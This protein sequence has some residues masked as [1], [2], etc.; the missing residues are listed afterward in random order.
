M[1]DG[2]IILV[3]DNE[4][5]LK[6]LRFVLSREFRTVVG[7]SNPSLLPA[8]LREEDV[9]VVLLDMNFSSGKH[10]GGEG[11]FWLDRIM[12]RTNPPEVVLITAFG[13]I[14]L[15]VASLKRGAADFIMKPWDN[16][17]LVATV[18]E[19]FARRAARHAPPAAPVSADLPP[20]PLKTETAPPSRPATLDEMEKQFITEVLRGNGGNLSLSA[21]QLDISRQTLYNKMRKYGMLV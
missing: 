20:D 16:D 4:A 5:V 3:D 2:K 1:V 13:E 21:Q 9:D 17:R 19:A 7:V 12:E 6:T 10:D 18:A 11:L 14:P 15:A 8:L